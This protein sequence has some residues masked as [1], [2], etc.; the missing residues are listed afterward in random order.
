MAEKIVEQ[1]EIYASGSLKRFPIKVLQGKLGSFLRLR[2]G[3]YR[4]MFEVEEGVMYIYE[5]KHRQGA[6]K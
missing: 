1:I 3:N 6:Y 2:V 5:I 4:V